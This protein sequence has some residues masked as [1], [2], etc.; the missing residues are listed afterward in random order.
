[1]E[2]DRGAGAAETP[3]RSTRSGSSGSSTTTCRTMRSSPP[4]RARPRTGSRATLKLKPSHLASLSGTLAT[5][6]PGRAVRDRREVRVSR[7]AGDRARRRRRDADERHGRADHGRQ[8]LRPLGR[9]AARRARAQQ[10][11]PEPGD[12]GAAGDGGRPEEPG[13]PDDSRRPLRRL[14]AADRPATASGSSRPTRSALPGRRRS[15][16]TGRS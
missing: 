6:G 16:P 15:R 1:M 13:D 4:T 10:P 8:V 11:R 2:A 3:T 7:P 9:P 14:R 12:V 5:M